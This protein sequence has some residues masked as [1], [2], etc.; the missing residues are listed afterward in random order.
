MEFGRL[1]EEYFLNRGF[2]A[3]RSIE[4]TLDLGWNLLSVLPRNA[5]DR[6]DDKVLDQFYDHD[7][8]VRSFNLQEDGVIKELQEAVK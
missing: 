2:E 4:E 6:V 7:K 8:A 1:F 3:N 5:L